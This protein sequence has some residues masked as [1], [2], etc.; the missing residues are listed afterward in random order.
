MSRYPSTDGDLAFVV[1]DEVPADA[2][3]ETL[4]ASGG[5]LL[6]KVWLF[7][8]FR[9]AGPAESASGASLTGYVSARRIARSPTRRSPS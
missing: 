4:R 1:P 9:G 6:E 7:D 5:P 8:V 2:V 3:E